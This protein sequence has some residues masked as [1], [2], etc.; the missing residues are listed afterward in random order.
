MKPG[1]RKGFPYLW[2]EADSSSLFY[3]AYLRCGVIKTR[4]SAC[5][6]TVSMVAPFQKCCLV[7]K[8]CLTLWDSIDFTPPGSYVHRVSQQGY[9]NGLLFPSLGHLL[10]PGI[11]P[12]SPESPALAG[13]FFQ[14]EP[15]GC[16]CANIT[17][18]LQ[19]LGAGNPKSNRRIST[20]FMNTSL[21]PLFQIHICH[22]PFP[23]SK[24]SKTL[25]HKLKLSTKILNPI[26]G[27]KKC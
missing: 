27:K 15:Q 13:Q 16:I 23:S 26:G 1:A 6:E 20:I 21:W 2:K 11:E 3:F 24:G 14:T 25:S 17:P 5:W 10:D 9:W 19:S 4:P 12:K 22:F 18:V 8:S 7:A